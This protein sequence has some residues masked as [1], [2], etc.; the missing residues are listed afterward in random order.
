MVDITNF[1]FN[2]IKPAVLALYSNAVVSKTY[3]NT[4]TTFP[5]VTFID[6]DNPETSHT[7]SYTQRKSRPSWQIDI[8]M[9]G[10]TKETV[11]KQIAAAIADVMENQLHMNRVA[12]KP[13]TNAA[14]TTIY[15]YTMIYSCNLDEDT[16]R[17]YS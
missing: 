5:Y 7:L 8:Y 10:G 11:S 14:D 9:T 4:T 17:I 16:Q 15:R 13:V 2:K 12:A 1:V 3:Q 6:I